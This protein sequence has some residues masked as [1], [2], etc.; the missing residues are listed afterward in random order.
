MY[1]IDKIV[2]MAQATMAVKSLNDA[3]CCLKTRRTMAT[4]M[5]IVSRMRSSRA[6]LRSLSLFVSRAMSGI[7]GA[8]DSNMMRDFYINLSILALISLQEMSAILKF[9]YFFEG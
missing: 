6:R 1:F 5:L 8:E 3:E 7:C 9:T 2:V 4:M